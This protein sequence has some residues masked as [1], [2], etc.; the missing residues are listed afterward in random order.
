MVELG[1]HLHADHSGGDA[2]ESGIERPE[3]GCSEC[4]LENAA[5][6]PPSAPHVWSGEGLPASSNYTAIS[7]PRGGLGN[8][9]A[10]F[11][12]PCIRSRC[13]LGD[14]PPSL[15]CTHHLLTWVLSFLGG[16]HG[17]LGPELE[18]LAP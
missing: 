9:T 1:I 10:R 4:D 8:N 7:S 2:G 12:R 6:S 17:L 15:S 11:L 18:P 13:E 14:E 5:V 16:V 3:A